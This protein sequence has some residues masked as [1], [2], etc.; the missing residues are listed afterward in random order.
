MTDQSHEES[1]PGA[2]QILAALDRTG[3]ILEYRLHQALKKLEFNSFLNHAFEDP[4]T[5]KSREIDVIASA[6]NFVEL[7]GGSKIIIDATIIAECKNYVDPLVVI[8][9][10]EGFGFQH[11][12]PIITFDPLRIEFAKRRPRSHDEL[13]RQLSLWNLPSHSTKGFIGS[14]LIKMHRKGGTWLASNDSVYDSIVYPLAKAVHAEETEARGSASD[15][16]S[17]PTFAYHFPV[18]VTAGKVFAVDVVEDEAPSVNPVIWAPLVRHF[19]DRAFMM[20]VVTFDGIEGYVNERI[21]PL[22]DEVERIL[23]DNLNFFNPEWLRQEYGKSSDPDFVK[24]LEDYRSS[25]E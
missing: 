6:N 16:W 21:F 4:D 12:H 5:G 14:Q 2:Q 10:N 23:E 1:I 7:P 20:D 9:S 13:S 22:L 8:G 3:F 18:L 25:S 17:L 15:T 11:A 24:W 19:S